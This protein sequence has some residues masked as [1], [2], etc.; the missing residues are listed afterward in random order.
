MFRFADPLYLLL[1]IILL[2]MAFWY[3]KGTRRSKG[4]LKYSDIAIIKRLPVSLKQRLRSVLF[5]MRLLG[6]AL[7]ILALA[8]PRSSSKEREVNTRGID[9]MLAMD[10]SSSM[11]AEDFKPHN[12]LEAA[13]LVA[14]DF[15]KGR[16]S[17]R[18]GLVIFAGESFT[19]CPLT[20]DYGVVLSLLDK[21]KVADKDWDGTAIGMG[22]VNAVNRLRD[23]KAKSKV[24]ILLTDGVNNRGQVDPITAARVAEAFHIKI[25]TIG[26][27]TRGTA[28]YPVQDPV[29][30]KHY[31]PMQVQIDEESLRSI[32]KITGGKYFRATDTKKLRD[33]YKEISELEKTK[34]EVK[35]YTRYEEYFVWFI[36][37]GLLLL[38]LEILLANTYFR[39]IP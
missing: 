6:V 11:L 30:G 3:W 27:G 2:P 13:K 32:A 34:I 17:D 8:R 7:L 29:L 33:I 21:L 20:L 15:V 19:Q 38:L 1:L 16:S 12:R 37:A 25:Y 26:A 4:R 9:I 10:V 28:M 23:S 39:K 35:E 5:I 18:I 24:I 22:L 31:M 36:G 14:D